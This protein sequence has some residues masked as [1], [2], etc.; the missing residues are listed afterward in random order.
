MESRAVSRVF[1]EGVASSGTK[2]LTG[3]TLGAAG[4]TELAFCWLALQSGR[5]PPH[6]WDGKA[7]LDL[8]QLDLVGAEQNFVR[9]A[10]RVCMS[11]SFAFGGSNASLLIGDNR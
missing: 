11:N 10:S 3:H 4:A 2:P 5:L 9:G 8:P 6:I 7:D 1:P